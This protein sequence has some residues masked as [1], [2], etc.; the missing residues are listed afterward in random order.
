MAW[1]TA[2]S[3]GECTIHETR[4]KTFLLLAFAATASFGAFAKLPYL[5]SLID[6][7]VIVRWETSTSQA[8][9]VEYGLTS[10][11]GTEV[12]DPNSTVDHEL[13]L[14]GLIEDTVYHYRAIS[15]SDTS[16]DATFQ[17]NVTADRPFRFVA[18]GDHR[19]DSA[20]HQRVVNRILA[21]S[22]LPSFGV[23][24][25]DLTYDGSAPV[26][27]TFFNVERGLWS[28][29]P[30]YPSLGNHDVNNV[31]NWLRFLAL[32]NNERWYTFHYGNSAFHCLDVYSTYT[33]GSTQYN[34]LVSELQADSANPAIRHIFV[35]FHEPP[36]T[37]NT[38]HASNTTVRQ[39]LCPLFEQY[40]VAIAFQGHVHCYEHALVNGVHYIITG[41]G[42][43]PL[44]TGWNPPQPWDIYRETTLEF[45]L[46]EVNGD[47]IRARAI[48]PDG[49]E[50]D[51]LVLGPAGIQESPKPEARRSNHG[52]QLTNV[53]S[54]T[55]GRIQLRFTL[56]ESGQVD[57]LLYDAAGR[58]VARLA[59]GLFA[60][61]E[62]E[63]S[64][65]R[66]RLEPGTYSLVIESA[67]S[68][69]AERVV[70]L[71]KR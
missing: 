37:T 55:A 42:G 22:P 53:L 46:V 13:T 28:R 16:Q 11:Y 71:G 12:S 9:K 63:V 38:G 65:D 47:T 64:W 17:S 30:V 10:S 57:V 19:S 31:T 59:R 34:W 40:H 61:G 69:R 25:G 58:R 39:Y 4:D 7:T 33:P 68:V 23:D 51:S 35:F 66:K 20:S 48:R 49:T 14:T 52:V 43:A 67:G 8:G 50:F 1:P 24:N 2:D 5:Q 32:P 15:G 56:P 3:P 27:Q 6:S 26:Y 62:H 36:Y 29:V 44:Y 41:G 21:Q 70:V 18:Y 45:V 54:P 60:A